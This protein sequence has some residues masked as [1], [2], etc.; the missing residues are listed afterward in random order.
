[1]YG[2]RIRAGARKM[3]H[4]RLAIFCGCT[5]VSDPRQRKRPNTENAWEFEEFGSSAD[6]DT[7][8]N[9]DVR[10]APESLVLWPA[11]KGAVPCTQHARKQNQEVARGLLQ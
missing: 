7:A 4:M 2:A 5:T 8:I 11:A 1:M 9:I 3:M 6:G 10:V